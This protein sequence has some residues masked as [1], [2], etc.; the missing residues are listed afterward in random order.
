MLI[1]IAIESNL[2]WSLIINQL[3]QYYILIHLY[4]SVFV[5][6]CLFRPIN[7]LYEA[8]YATPRWQKRGLEMSRTWPEMFQRQVRVVVAERHM[9]AGSSVSPHQPSIALLINK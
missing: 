8:D 1:T 2:L 7:S 4:V 6:T 3:Y 9:L 5:W